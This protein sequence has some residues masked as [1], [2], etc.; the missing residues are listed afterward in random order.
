MAYTPRSSDEIL[1]DLAS[2]FVARS[3]SVDDLREG[4]VL[5]VLLASVA[6]QLAEADT[7]LEQIHLQ[8]TM[9]G[10]TGADLDAR[11]S[12]MGVTRSS[13]K[14]ASGE[15]LLTRTSADNSIIIPAGSTVGSTL[16][17]VTYATLETVTM[18]GTEAQ[19]RVV[20]Q[21]NGIVGNIPP[22]TLNLLIDIPDGV[23]GIEQ[24]N[25]FTN[26]AE[27]ESD[28]ALKSRARLAIDKLTRCT[29]SALRFEALSFRASDE[30]QATTA[31][32]YEPVDKKGYVELLIDDGSGI[33]DQPNQRQGQT[34]TQTV[35][36]NALPYV[37]SVERGITDRGIIIRRNRGGAEITLS[38]DQYTV[39]LSQGLVYI[40]EGVEP[41]DTVIATNYSVYTGLTAELQAHIEGE[42]DNPSTGF[43]PAGIDVRVL[44]APVQRVS[45][46]ILLTAQ[47]GTNILTTIDDIKLAC[48][49]Y[50]NQLDAGSPAFIAG[51]IDVAMD[52]I[53]VMNVKVLTSNNRDATDT[54][55]RS[56]RHVIRAGT[57]NVITSTTEG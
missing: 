25:A 57:I 21:T 33:G 32:I 42:Y 3:P 9:T 50:I 20:A 4:S 53:G 46:N 41:N 31:T 54:Y 8:Y 56:P 1:R 45:F 16:T 12:E 2:R 34:I 35:L 38:P 48:S 15:I 49:A 28:E 10:A 43:R 39:S 37:F 26:G 29:S 19:V 17:D 44:P 30:T 5:F 27:A 51:L 36:S 23:L 13:A 24:S 52:V 6:E 40:N 47:N 18:A 11:A 14:P 22:N 55:P 7:R